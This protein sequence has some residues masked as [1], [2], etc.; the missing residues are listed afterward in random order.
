MLTMRS[1]S[2]GVLF[3]M[4]QVGVS[5]AATLPSLVFPGTDADAMSSVSQQFRDREADAR[6][7]WDSG[8]T[9]KSRA[10]LLAEIASGPPGDAAA[11]KLRLAYQYNSVRT[12]TGPRDPNGRRLFAELTE[13]PSG[14]NDR[15]RG[16]AAVRLAHLSNREIGGK[17]LC[18]RILGGQYLV[19]H[20][21]Y[22]EIA[23]MRAA[24]HH[25]EMKHLSAIPYYEALAANSRKSEYRAKAETE[26]AGLWIELAK[27]E[28]RETTA[29]DRSDC[30]AKAREH[31]QEV[32]QTS[33]TVD[34]RYAMVA[35]LMHGETYFFQHDYERSYEAMSDFCR[36]WGT[37]A[38]VY[39]P[40]SN[41][42][43]YL[44]AALPFQMQNCYLTGRTIEALAMAEKAT[45]AVL[46][47]ADKF[48]LAEPYIYGAVIGKL[49]ALELGKP[50]LAGQFQQAGTAYDSLY[51]DSLEAEL[52]RDRQATG[53]RSGSK[54]ANE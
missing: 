43:K 15:A 30:F 42:R 34:R 45:V 2:A 54:D 1:L 16:E 24:I 33:G 9:T 46:P 36:A 37:D 7:L 47:A 39:P 35:H 13:L 11:A 49:A 44:N 21:E 38:G 4:A 52:R 40:G 8:E 23:M 32:L 27:G 50:G 51:F 12:A 26:L 41:E 3:Y 25:R 22:C 53:D 31:C 28:C 6:R 20:D 10:I 18:D 5:H 17:D 29:P 19:T 14:V 48:R